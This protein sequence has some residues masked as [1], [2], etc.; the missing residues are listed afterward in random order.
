M[1]ITVPCEAQLFDPLSIASAEIDNELITIARF[2]ESNYAYA[3]SDGKKAI[4]TFP[5]GDH[6]DCLFSIRLEYTQV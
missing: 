4:F 6:E 5:D 2:D 1:G 3:V